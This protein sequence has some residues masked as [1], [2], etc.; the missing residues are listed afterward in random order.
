MI[1]QNEKCL[2]NFASIDVSKSDVCAKVL[3]YINMKNLFN[4]LL[5]VSMVMMLGSCEQEALQKNEQNHTK[6]ALTP[7]EEF[8]YA[9]DVEF[10]ADNGD[11]ATMRVYGDSENELSLYSNKNFKLIPLNKGESLKEGLIRNNLMELS[12]VEEETYLEPEDDLTDDDSN[13][14]SDLAFQIVKAPSCE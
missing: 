5:M 11:R 14:K 9:K 1:H 3:I 13:I 4:F 10:T 7:E 2:G 8:K 6:E 12:E